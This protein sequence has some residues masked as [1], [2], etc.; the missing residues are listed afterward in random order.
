MSV[1]T[2][3]RRFG[4]IICVVL[5]AALCMAALFLYRPYTIPAPKCAPAQATC[6]TGQATDKHKQLDVTELPGLTIP[7]TT[8]QGGTGISGLIPLGTLLFGSGT[9]VLSQ[10]T[11]GAEGQVLTVRGG[12]PVWGRGSN[13]TIL[14]GG[15]TNGTG[16]AG[17]SE[18]TS[19]PGNTGGTT[20]TAGS[21][22]L[23]TS[24]VFSLDAAN[25]NDWT[26]VQDFQN[27]LTINGATF[28]NLT[29]ADSTTLQ[30][31]TAGITAF[32]LNNIGSG[33]QDFN[34]ADGGIQTNGISRLTNSG[35]LQNITGLTIGTS[36]SRSSPIITL[37]NTAGTTAV[38][39][40]NASPESD[41]A[42][43]IGALAINSAN[44]T[45][46]I[47]TSG[48]GSTGWSQF[49][50]VSACTAT[51]C[52]FSSTGTNTID[53]S[54]ANGGLRL[55]SNGTG[56]VSLDSGTTGA[57]NIGTGTNTKAL[58]IGNGS[59][60]TSL[61]IQVG[62]G[63]VI[64]FGGT[65]GVGIYSSSTNI[66][67]SFIVGGTLSLATRT[68]ANLPAGGDIGTAANTVDAASSFYSYQTT[69]DQTLT[70][71]TPTATYYS[72]IVYMSNT[73][74]VPFTFYGL[75]VPVGQSAL[76]IWSSTSWKL[77][78]APT[79]P[80]AACANT[81]CTFTGTSANIITTS[82]TTSAL[83]I[84]GGGTGGVS[85]DGGAGNLS[86]GSGSG[87][88]VN[89]GTGSVAKTITLGNA[90]GATALTLNSG[91]GG[92]T[93]NGG[94]GGLIFNTAS[95]GNIRFAANGTG[96]T[97]F[98]TITNGMTISG[99]GIVNFVGTA[100]PTQHVNLNPEYPGGT[101]TPSGIN[102]TGTMTSDYCSN[103]LAINIAVCSTAGDI[104]SY[105]S[106][107]GTTGT[108]QNYDI[109]VRYRVP[110][111][112]SAFT[113]TFKTYGWRTS[114]SDS[115]TVNVYNGSTACGTFTATSTNA[116]WTQGTVTP[117]CTAVPGDMLTFKVNVAATSAEYARAG[118][119]DFDYLGKF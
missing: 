111:D 75:V 14:S 106:W 105:Y 23:L 29:D 47:K 8:L 22:L 40:T 13:I 72:R 98:G 81:G 25:P 82:G 17:T 95:N 55:T 85:I 32:T 71:P 5:V 15:S 86:V 46:F 41:I 69:P 84:T 68:V 56:A 52:T 96:L 61:Q 79:P 35:T 57:V 109:Y 74:Y 31:D 93:L 6:R 30:T 10:L 65:G 12:V 64:I 73:G 78:G 45:M 33:I 87:T 108:V 77:V 58:T 89:I 2:N 16:S 112:F 59:G 3:T 63:G 43:T 88:T 44:G 118:E 76:A 11:I 60:G 115:V 50:S 19:D 114:A 102:N 18:N 66:S 99:G 104:H 94:S 37:G 34:V 67:G 101:L 36:A 80:V 39:T 117:T 116:T 4:Q 26:G 90:V 110:N 24:T 27:G 100:R 48:S 21:G 103:S 38:Y 83:S 9:T 107:T 92:T 119:I 53:V 113:G 49:G 97:I 20:Y 70:L 42:A 51:G 28:T 1:S 7:I 54:G 62:T 91:S